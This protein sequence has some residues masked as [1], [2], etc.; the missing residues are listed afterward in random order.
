ME[1]SKDV[2]KT[3]AENIASFSVVKDQ[4]SQKTCAACVQRRMPDFCSDLLMLVESEPVQSNL[5]YQ[6][7]ARGPACPRVFH[8]D[9]CHHIIDASRNNLGAF[10]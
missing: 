7:L 9:A 10:R 3:F 5:K 8:L 1:R 6:L 2:P 4:I